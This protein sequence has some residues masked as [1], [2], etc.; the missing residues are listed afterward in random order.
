MLLRIVQWQRVYRAHRDLDAVTARIYS[1]WNYGAKNVAPPLR[2]RPV[3]WAKRRSHFSY[4]YM[5]RRGK[6]ILVKSLDETWSQEWLFWPGPSTIYPTD[7]LDHDKWETRP[8][9]REGA[10]HRQNRNC[11]T[12]TKIWSSTPEGAWHEDWLADWSS[13]VMW[14]WLDFNSTYKLDE[15]QSPS[16]VSCGLELDVRW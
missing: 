12:V 15:S 3:L 5:S 8:L 16:W 11:L 2:D 1:C 4:T 13:V 7:R 9:V 10:R 14:L 6:K